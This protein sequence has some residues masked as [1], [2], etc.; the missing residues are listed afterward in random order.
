[1]RKSYGNRKELK[2]Q[3]VL[4]L[5]QLSM[6]YRGT[7]QLE[8]AVEVLREAREAMG[9]ILEIEIGVSYLLIEAECYS[10]LQQKSLTFIMEPSIETLRQQLDLEL[11][12]AKEAVRRNQCPPTARPRRDRQQSIAE[13]EFKSLQLKMSKMQFGDYQIKKSLVTGQ[14]HSSMTPLK[15]LQ[16][17]TL[18]DMKVPMVHTGKYLACRIISEAY[19][20]VATAFLIEDLNGE[21]EIVS[22][23]NFQLNIGNSCSWLPPGT[24]MFIKEPYLKFG[25]IG[26]DLI[27]RVDSPSDV[28]F[29]DESDQQRLQ[30]AN[31]LQ[32]YNPQKLSVDQLRARGNQYYVEKNYEWA[33]K[34]YKKALIIEP[35]SGVLHLN[36]A[37]AYIATDNYHAAFES[38]KL[39]LE[40]GADKEKAL[41]GL[42]RG[43][44][45]LRNWKLACQYFKQ[46][47][48]NYPSNNEAKVEF[49]N[50]LA[51]LHESETGQYDLV[52]LYNLSAKQQVR[53]L[54]VADYT[55][56]VCIADVQGKGKGLVA[57]R[58]VPR[59]TLLLV[60]KAFSVAYKDELPNADVF[61][62]NLLTNKA[63]RSSQALNIIRTMQ[64]LKCNPE[65]A[66]DLYA[67]FAGNL[68]RD[69]R[70][71][72]DKVI[73]AARIENICSFNCFGDR[74]DHDSAVEGEQTDELSSNTGL[75]ILPSFINH[76]CIDPCY[77]QRNK[78]AERCHAL[79]QLSFNNP[80]QALRQLEP[81]VKE[82]RRSYGSRKELKIQI[83]L[84]LSQLSMVYKTTHQL[85]KAAEVLREA[86]EAMSHILEIEIGVSHLLSEADCYAGLQQWSQVAKTVQRAMTNT[87]I[88][89]GANKQL[90]Y[91]M[92]PRQCDSSNSFL[93]FS[94]YKKYQIY[95]SIYLLSIA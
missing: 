62:L 27:I 74:N 9:Q 65:M 29:V 55:G 43:A 71:P 61:C 77:E 32:W 70:I 82:M 60:S 86:R 35:D 38:A 30:W 67:L 19:I 90:F 4:P 72:A 85:E 45:G 15:E 80:Q 23:Y 8:K 40:K 73:D 42:G 89:C 14:S 1:M 2:T 76:S 26:R 18:R 88:R 51:R 50:T 58:D 83:I 28:V 92:F 59:G 91:L 36:M 5:S 25:S 69:H 78:L 16:P 66:A 46:L 22:L 33:L 44:Y 11:R 37:A 47:I 20:L 34:Y 31:A 64:T 87:K 68:S 54:D 75:W 39:A 3:I 7:H 6:V 12:N 13:M 53:R 41:M 17:I 57:S 10:G 56:P 95:L 63:D 52:K 79:K 24:I 49:K 48:Q 21:V 84:P 81:L 94:L 93:V